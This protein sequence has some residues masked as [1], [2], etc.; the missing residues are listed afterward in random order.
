MRIVNID[1]YRRIITDVL[2]RIDDI[3]LSL[4]VLGGRDGVF[5]LANSMI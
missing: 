5:V 3:C 4:C 2:I 1:E